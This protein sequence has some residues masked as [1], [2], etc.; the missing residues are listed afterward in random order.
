MEKFE[1]VYCYR[2]GHNLYY[3]EEFKT[4]ILNL[5]KKR[6][7]LSISSITRFY[8]IK[9]THTISRWAKKEQEDIEDVEFF[10]LRD[11]KKNDSKPAVEPIKPEAMSSDNELTTLKIKLAE[12]LAV[13]KKQEAIIDG[14]EAL[15]TVTNR[16]YKT[17]LK[18]KY[19][20]KRSQS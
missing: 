12:A 14:L 11:M 6:P 16:M 10:Y 7:D 18:K 13:N 15:I 8:N 19:G 5:I 1:S 20:T 4:F 9:G 2:K 17:D 3:T